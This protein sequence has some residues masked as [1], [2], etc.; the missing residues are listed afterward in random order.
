MHAS[1]IL[2]I[3]QS[4]NSRWAKET[5]SKQPLVIVVDWGKPNINVEPNAFWRIS[6]LRYSSI[7]LNT[8][9]K[10][11]FWRQKNMPWSH[12]VSLLQ[13]LVLQHSSHPQDPTKQLYVFIFYLKNTLHCNDI[14]PP[15]KKKKTNNQG[16]EWALVA[17]AA[18]VVSEP[19]SRNSVEHSGHC[20]VVFE[21]DHACSS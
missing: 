19:N 4:R 11:H 13:R 14:S 1:T 18:R 2:Y 8:T 10:A 9:A 17:C 16:T 5:F 12:M 7:T 21:E 20:H 15:K 6:E 3:S